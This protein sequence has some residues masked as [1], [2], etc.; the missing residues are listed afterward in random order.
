M[1]NKAGYGV[2]LWL[3][4]IEWSK[5]EVIRQGIRLGVD[6]SET[7]SCYTPSDDGKACGK[8]RACWKRTDA[9]RQEGIPDP[10]IYMEV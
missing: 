4:V 9:F 8:C 6:F 1:I 2:K 3:P 5:G 7:V 10:T